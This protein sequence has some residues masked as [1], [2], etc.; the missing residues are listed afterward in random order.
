MQNLYIPNISE[1]KNVR[2]ETHDVK[3]FRFPKTFDYAPGQF[4][5]LSILGVGECPISITSSPTRDFL[6]ISVKLM[7]SVTSALHDLE[8]GDKV[9]IRGPYGNGFPIGS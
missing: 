5:E 4:I 8:E 2:T 6:E 3:T 9:Y 7:G 1:I